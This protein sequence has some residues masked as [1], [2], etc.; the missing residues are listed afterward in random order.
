MFKSNKQKLFRTISFKN[1]QRKKMSH[2]VGHFPNNFPDYSPNN[3]L[4]SEKSLLNRNTSIVLGLNSKWETTS[5]RLKEIELSDYSIYTGST[6]IALLR[7]LKEP[8]NKPNLKE[9]KR[10]CSLPKLKKRRHTFLCGDAGPLAI[11]AIACDRLGEIENRNDCLRRLLSLQEEAVD[12]ESDLP[13]EYLYGRAGYLFSLL[14]VNKNIDPSPIPENVIQKVIEAMLFIGQKEAKAGKFKCPLMYE[15]HGKYYL[16]AAHGVAGILYLLLQAKQYLTESE[17]NDLIKPTI[18]FLTTTRFANG[19]YPS[20]WKSNTD[21]VQWCH[22]APGFV[23]LFSEA[24]KVFG[25]EKYLKL[26]IEAGE[27]VW[28]RG[29]LQKGYSICHGVSGN[30]YAFLELFQT[31]KD[32]KYLYRAAKFAEWCMNYRKENEYHSP[33]RPL[34]LFEGI[35]GPMYFLIDIQDPMNAKFPGF[36]L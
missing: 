4:I 1:S 20:S 8:F 26:A 22:G 9:V 10:L 36:T 19:N 14:F 11:G 3:T 35:A 34:S 12:P 2:I 16:G 31:T 25:E 29:L 5:L 28:E 27:I 32:P 17:L 13:N 18:E 21:K 15:W 23:F 7:L 33:D 30:G 6:G 24:Y